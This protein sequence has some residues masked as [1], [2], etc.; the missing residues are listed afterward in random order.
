MIAARIV[1][2]MIIIWCSKGLAV[3][4]ESDIVYQPETRN[5]KGNC[6]KIG[7]SK[8]QEELKRRQTGGKME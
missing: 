8:R 5:K 3:F 6:D 2:L 1:T 4:L 7:R